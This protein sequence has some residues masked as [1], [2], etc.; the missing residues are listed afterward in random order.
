MD[1]HLKWETLS[2]EY[3]AKESWF[4]VRRDTCKRSDGKIISNYFVFEFPEWATAFPITA[5][6]KILMTKQYRHAI[7]EVCIELPGGCVDAT[8][9]TYEDAI[10]RELLEETGYEFD[11][12][13]PLGKISANPSTNSNLMHMFLATGGKKVNQQSLDDNEEIELIELSFDDLM[14]LI[15]ENK[16]L[17]AMHMTTIYYALKYLGIEVP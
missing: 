14:Q 9:K 5:E 7:N 3:V 6:G 13:K 16:I 1:E 15:D 11:D 12:I 10:R 4:T 2:S 8:D 17:Q